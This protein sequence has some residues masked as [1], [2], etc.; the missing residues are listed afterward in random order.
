MAAKRKTRK[1]T[2]RATR[3]TRSKRSRTQDRRR[4]AG[5]QKYEVSYMARK[6][7]RSASAVREAI[8]IVGNLRKKLE[9]ALRG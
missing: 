8:K 2:T 4:V 7:G 6:S 5:G 3:T 1:S 9:R